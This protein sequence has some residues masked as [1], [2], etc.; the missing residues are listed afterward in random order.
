VEARTPDGSTDIEAVASHAECQA[1][2][3]GYPSMAGY[4]REQ[5]NRR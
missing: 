2:V 1:I 4:A 5:V 3:R